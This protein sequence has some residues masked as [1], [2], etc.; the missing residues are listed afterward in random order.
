MTQTQ[1]NKIR[2]SNIDK[3]YFAGVIDSGWR[4]LRN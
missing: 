4:G 2:L 1:E 3:A